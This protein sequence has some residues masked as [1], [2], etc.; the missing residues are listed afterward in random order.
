LPALWQ[1]AK[2]LADLLTAQQCE[3]T[4]VEATLTETNTGIDAA[5]SWPTP[6]SFALRDAL[7]IWARDQDIA[8]LTITHDG[9]N[10]PLATLRTPEIHFGSGKITPPPHIFLQPSAAGEQ[11]IA[12]RLHDF[13]NTQTR[14]LDLFC[15]AGSFTLPLAERAPVHGVDNAPLAMAA[16]QE[17][18]KS[19]GSGRVTTTIRDLFRTPL[20]TDEL[21]PYS[22][23]VIDPPRAGAKDQIEKIAALPKARQH[24][25]TQADRSPLLQSKNSIP[26]AGIKLAYISCN[27]ATF[28]RDAKV[29]LAAGWQLHAIHPIDQFP[30]SAH[31][32]LVALF[33]CP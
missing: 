12:A 28:T 22:G 16:L 18:A 11:A 15:G 26:S 27:P 10:D 6:L 30:K 23:I 5:L 14:I 8:R 19:F 21:L 31:L 20:R 13:F 7:I 33:S 3:T 9:F 4:G 2:S 17:G 1:T 24:T 25:T 32:E 29:L